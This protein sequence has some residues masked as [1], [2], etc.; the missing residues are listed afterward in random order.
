LGAIVLETLDE[1]PW[2]QLSHAFGTADEV[3]IWLRALAS[4]AGSKQL[5]AL[6]E[7][8]GTIWHQGT[9]YSATAPTIPFLI[10]LLEV[11]EAVVKAGILALLIECADGSGSMEIGGC[12]FSRLTPD[13]LEAR[14]CQELDWVCDSRAAVL[15]GQHIYRQLLQHEDLDVR[16]FAAELLEI[17]PEIDT[18]ERLQESLVRQATARSQSTLE[19]L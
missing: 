17:A 12:S 4:P 13:E 10:E 7:L 2:N 3:P 6:T 14:A 8:C 1:V 15:K 9:V 19:A 11:P 16:N 18:T 5:E